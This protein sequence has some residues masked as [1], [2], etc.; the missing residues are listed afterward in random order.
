MEETN[1]EEENETGEKGTEKRQKERKRMQKMGR[2]MTV[3]ENGEARSTGEE[4]ERRSET[5]LCRTVLLFSV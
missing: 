5:D 2:R 3:K 4:T 1:N